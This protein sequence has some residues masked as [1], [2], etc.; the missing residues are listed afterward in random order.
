MICRGIPSG[1]TRAD[2]RSNYRSGRCRCRRCRP[3]SIR[4]LRRLAADDADRAATSSRLSELNGVDQLLRSSRCRRGQAIA[5]AGASPGSVRS[6]PP[7]GSVADHGDD[8]RKPQP[9]ASVTATPEAAVTLGAHHLLIRGVPKHART[10]PSI[11]VLDKTSANLTL[12][13]LQ[14]LIRLD[15]MFDEVFAGRLRQPVSARR[16]VSGRRASKTKRPSS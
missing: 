10:S 7:S 9:R 11:S 1:D 3:S 8:E 6:S 16:V 4:R 5:H 12:A 2:G 13:R 14:I 15:A